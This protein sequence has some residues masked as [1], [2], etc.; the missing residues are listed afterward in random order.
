MKSVVTKL[1]LLFFSF[2]ILLS[3]KAEDVPI[4][5]STAWLKDH[6]QDKNLVLL[7]VDWT[8]MD[9]DREHIPTAQFLWPS[10]LAPNTPYGNM[11][12]PDTKEATKLL[13]GYGI[14]ND[15]HVVLYFTQNNV[16][17]TSRMFLSLEY[18]GLK[19]RVSLLDGGM[20]AWTKDG[21]TLTAEAPAMKK[22]NFK[23]VINPILVDKEYVLKNLESD[24]TTIVDARFKRYY[25]GDPVGYPRNGHIKGAKNIP[26]NEMVDENNFFKSDSDLSTYFE[27]VASKD[28][29][30]VMYCFIGQTA[31][32][33]YLAGR[34]LGYDIK[35]YDGSMEEWSRLD[36]LPM[37][38]SPKEE[39]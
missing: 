24:K 39:K 4:I 28:Q 29:E 1:S 2:L 22:G 37:E 33:V 14:S 13:Q 10:S 16:T 5:V 36:Q 26:Y 34:K 19:G 32:V 27:P 38:E 15:S 18:L 3:A 6:L 21:N 7:H 12:A 25:D 9:Y 11:N 20:N 30:V 8:K 35:L 23:A 31:C 17:V